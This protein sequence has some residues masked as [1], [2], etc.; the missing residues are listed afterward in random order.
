MGGS[1]GS[2]MPGE[3][4]LARFGLWPCSGGGRPGQS[5]LACWRPGQ[6]QDLAWP[7]Q[8]P[9]CKKREDVQTGLEC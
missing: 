9:S 6:G 2:R 1:G 4:R 8:S 3:L 5:G 7:G